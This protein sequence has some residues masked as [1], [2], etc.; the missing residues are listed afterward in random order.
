MSFHDPVL[1]TE[2]LEY[3]GPL[4]GGTLVDGTVGGGGHAALL[5]ESCGA[6]E[7]VGVDLDPE[8]LAE[9]GRRLATFGSR[10]R[11]VNARFDDALEVA[12]LTEGPLAGV[13]L[14]LGVSSHQLDQDIRGFTYRT[15][16]PLDMR[17][18]ERGETAADFLRTA[19]VG[20]LTEVFGGLGELPRPRAIANEVVRRREATGM[21]RSD[22]LVAALSRAL[23]K[24]P[25]HGEKARAFQ[26][27][28]IAVNDEMGALE[29]ALPRFREALAPGAA[30][31]VISYHS[32]EDRR[33]K[34]AFREWSRSCVCPP[35]LPKCVCRG[36]PLGRP[37]TKRPVLASPEEVERNP[38]ARSAKLRAWRKADT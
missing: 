12:G 19:D 16:S 11:F 32:L 30:L 4:D 6:C 33:V 35:R 17:M 24:S 14:D 7:L 5:L 18:G 34:Q 3:L 27:V 38:R 9:A 31:V 20:T 15:D 25:T 37:L 22:D 10:V 26:A 29:R 13:L 1:G 28:R 23:D 36:R 8:A 21:A 2:V